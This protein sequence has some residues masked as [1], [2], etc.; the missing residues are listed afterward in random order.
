MDVWPVFAT[1]FLRE[2][3][4]MTV[5]F[6]L[7]HDVLLTGPTGDFSSDGLIGPTTRTPTNACAQAAFVVAIPATAGEY[8]C[9]QPDARREQDRLRRPHGMGGICRPALN[10]VS[11]VPAVAIGGQESQRCNCPAASGW[12]GRLAARQVS[13]SDPAI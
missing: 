8:D 12:P 6:T 2:S 10:E 9:V 11:I 1:G 5:V 4:V 7:V 13:A 3:S